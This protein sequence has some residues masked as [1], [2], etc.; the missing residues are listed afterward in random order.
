MASWDDSKN[1]IDYGSVDTNVT[2]IDKSTIT[3]WCRIPGFPVYCAFPGKVLYVVSTDS[4][5]VSK[6][7]NGIISS[8]DGSINVSGSTSPSTSFVSSNPSE[9][10]PLP[11]V[12]ERTQEKYLFAQYVANIYNGSTKAYGHLMK[13]TILKQQSGSVEFWTVSASG[14]TVNWTVKQSFSLGETIT[15]PTSI[16]QYTTSSGKYTFTGK[17]SSSRGSS[18]QTTVKTGKVEDGD[19]LKYY[20]IYK[21]VQTPKFN[22][23]LTGNCGTNVSITATL[24]FST[25]SESPTVNYAFTKQYTID[26]SPF[27]DTVEVEL[28]P[29]NWYV[30]MVVNYIHANYNNQKPYINKMVLD[31]VEKTTYAGSITGCFG[32]WTLYSASTHTLN[33]SYSI[34]YT[35]IH[36]SEVDIPSSGSGGSTI[37]GEVVGTYTNIVSY[38]PPT[39]QGVLFENKTTTT[40]YIYQRSTLSS[41]TKKYEKIF[42][43]SPRQKTTTGK[44]GPFNFWWTTIDQGLETTELNNC[45]SIQLKSAT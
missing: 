44:G 8:S 9:N 3:C 29:G 37:S 13:W 43:L 42:T 1:L 27:T 15:A 26:K 45:N 20:A 28:D 16:S 22:I 14:S 24:Y 32:P 18:T 23:N 17:W 4:N 40:V 41:V 5:G 21:L 25:S 11:A 30:T 10:I 33:I 12:S 39:Y 19:N 6:I 31:G 2:S 35:D 36:G 38:N 34:K 7:S